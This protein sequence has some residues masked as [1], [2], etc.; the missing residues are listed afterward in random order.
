M[1][2]SLFGRRPP[3]ADLTL[4]RVRRIELGEDA[5]VDHLPGWVDGHAE[6][7]EVLRTTTGWERARRWMYDRTVDV[8][9]LFGS[10]PDD[11][12][13]HPILFELKEALTR[14]YG[15][16]YDRISIAYYRD[17][18]DSVAWHG[19]KVDGRDCVIPI[20]S[21]G[22]PRKFLMK[23]KASTRSLTFRVGWGDLLVMGGSCQ[24]T[25]RHAV[26]KQTYAD[27]RMAIMFRQSWIQE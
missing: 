7:F 18:Q 25:W 21:V 23:H 1:Q 12:P 5:W 4:S 14:R 27:P 19:D 17:G 10:I 6:L 2:Q 16:S 15:E 13:G 24:R 26:P 20:L 3:S 22:A 8:P 9:R 11:G